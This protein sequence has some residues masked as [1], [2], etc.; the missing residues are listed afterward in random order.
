MLQKIRI[1]KDP[2][3]ESLWFCATDFGVQTNIRS[4]RVLLR[5]GV[6]HKI[7]RWYGRDLRFI[8]ETSYRKLADTALI[9]ELNEYKRKLENTDQLY[10]NIVQLLKS[11]I[12]NLPDPIT[13]G[14]LK[15]IFKSELEDIIFIDPVVMELIPLY[16]QIVF[17]EGL[18][19]NY[20]LAAFMLEALPLCFSYN[21][22]ELEVCYNCNEKIPEPLFRGLL[23]YWNSPPIDIPPNLLVGLEDIFERDMGSELSKNYF[24]YPILNIRKNHL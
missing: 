23:K 9:E 7:I 16:T 22:K 1:H 4:D 10:G 19:S 14:K 3:D 24:Q 20:E 12:Y 17:Y 21:L 15:P 18:E 11:Y 6:V 13:I 5:K 8:D 2:V